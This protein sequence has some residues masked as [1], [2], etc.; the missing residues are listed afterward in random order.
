M[1]DASL[2]KGVEN[3][4]GIRSESRD[5]FHVRLED[6]INPCGGRSGDAAMAGDDG[7]TC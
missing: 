7:A 2:F 1:V 5:G 4:S 6:M 3:R